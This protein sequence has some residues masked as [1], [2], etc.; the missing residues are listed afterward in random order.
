MDRGSSAERR[1]RLEHVGAVMGEVGDAPV[2]RQARID[3][4]HQHGEALDDLAH[5]RRVQRRQVVEV[6]EHRAH[7]H[8][9]PLGDARRRGAHI[10]FFDEGDAGIDDGIAG[11]GRPGGPPVDGNGGF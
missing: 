5:D 9:G 1:H 10:A 3:G 11:A 2:E 6:L 4:H 8:A 7:R